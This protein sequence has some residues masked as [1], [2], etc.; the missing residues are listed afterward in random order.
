MMWE[1]ETV[2]PHLDPDGVLS[3]DDVVSVESLKHLFRKNAFPSFCENRV[4][5][6]ATFQ[7]FGIALKGAA[8]RVTVSAISP[9][10]A[11]P[12]FAALL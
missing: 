7:N 10:M 11:L 6:W 3:S 1:F 9:A 8:E 4:Q 2:Y 5:Q 12:G